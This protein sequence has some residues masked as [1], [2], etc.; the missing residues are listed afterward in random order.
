M[1]IAS[2]I[3][4]MTEHLTSDWNIIDSLG[5]Y[6][7]K[8]QKEYTQVDYIE[9]S[10]NQ[11]I[12]T[13]VNADYKLD[14]KYTIEKAVSG[15]LIFGAIY[16]NN[17]SYIRYHAGVNRNKYSF[18]I[19]NNS[20]F[21]TINDDANVKHDFYIKATDRT[22]S[23]DGTTYE[24]PET[25]T[26]DTGLNFWLFRRNSNTTNL[27][28][29]SSLKLYSCQMYYENE[30]VR[31]F[32]PCY[33]NSDNEVGLYDL[34]NDVFY[35]NQGTGAFTYGQVQEE[36]IDKNIENIKE[37]LDLFYNEV[38]DKTNLSQ[39]GVVGRTSQESTTGKNLIKFSDAK[40]YA[41]IN[42]VP[43][44]LTGT[45]YVTS[46]D[47]N[48]FSI[49]YLSNLFIG[50]VSDIME[51][52][53]DTQYTISFN[54]T[55]NSNFQQ[56]VH[57][58]NV[59]IDGTLSL[60]RA[61][62]AGVYGSPYTYTFTT[63]ETGRTAIMISVNNSTPRG[64]SE[65]IKNIQV[66]LGST[67][68]EFE[69]YTNGA[70]PNPDYPQPINNL[71]RDVPY[72]VSGKNL[73]KASSSNYKQGLT[74]TYDS[75]TGEIT[76][77]GTTTGGYPTLSNY[78][79]TYIPA[80]TYTFS[81]DKTLPYTIFCRFRNASGQ[82]P[83]VISIGSGELSKTITT[84]YDAVRLELVY[85]VVTSGITIPETTIKPMI[86][87]GL[88]ASTF[89]PYISQIFN[90]PLKSKNLFDKD[91]ED[92]GHVYSSTGSYDI[93]G[94]WNTSDWIKAS[95]Y[96]TISA[97]TTGSMNILLSEFDNSK[98][99]IQRTQQMATSK[100][101][102]LNTNTKYV[103]LSYK[104]D[105]GIYDIQIEESS[106]PTDYESYYDIE[107]CEIDTY[108]D[109]IYSSNGRFY[110]YKETTKYNLFELPYT[111]SGS[112][113]T[114]VDR[115]S[116]LVTNMGFKSTYLSNIV[117]SSL[118]NDS[119]IPNRVITNMGTTGTWWLTLTNNLT[120]VN[121]SD[122]NTTK[123]SKIITYLQSKKAVLITYLTTPTTTEITQENYPSLYNA[124]KQIQDYLTSYKINKEF[125]LGYSSPE[126]EY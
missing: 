119:S 52:Q 123:V 78:T 18:F 17:G 84:T 7:K 54:R 42:G 85:S 102:N 61:N 75:D 116:L 24:M 117:K 60:N 106:A 104:N 74:I 26:T 15:S 19:L 62:N 13:G 83:T 99:F 20:T 124:L 37:P 23:V 109:K 89:E 40:S 87:K 58:L 57:F 4:S 46:S 112:S 47:D 80:G 113:T 86:E 126:I 29:Y 30:L 3:E 21:T 120:G 31:D 41:Y 2:R 43:A 69:P 65:T 90:I 59:A 25:T 38:S 45:N 71:S 105:I 55:Q 121:S 108:E 53:P 28:N 93:S 107:L 96:I 72:K 34:V 79:N 73:F 39:N 33:R 22:V 1:S 122:D 110:L 6:A 76:F 100:T 32:I 14:I 5:L 50:V 98:I 49:T 44:N 101:Y 91:S 114:P 66:E 36:H 64:E 77:G 70:S 48:S 11:Y 118:Q 88:A 35:T 63:G 10:S 8:L 97:S 12:D 103:R 111:Y 92:I 9:S 95:D 94:L 67:A 81:I 68:T 115:T 56:R 125:I 51:L 16:N 27:M 82:Y